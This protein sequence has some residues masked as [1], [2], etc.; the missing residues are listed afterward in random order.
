MNYTHSMYEQVATVVK[1]ATDNW[2]GDGKIG[3][4]ILEHAVTHHEGHQLL[5]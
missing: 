1:E 3:Q 2:V 4:L 5:L